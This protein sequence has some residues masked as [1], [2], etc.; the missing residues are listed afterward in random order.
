MVII[1]STCKAVSRQ[2]AVFIASLL[3]FALLAI[4][5]LGCLAAKEVATNT[6]YVKIKPGAD[7]SQNPNDLA[8][9]IARRNGFHNLGPVSPSILRF[10]KSLRILNDIFSFLSLFLLIS[11]IN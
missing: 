11:F 8:H 7:G 4:D 2:I 6:F 9:Q 1:K 5:H 3:F 10:E